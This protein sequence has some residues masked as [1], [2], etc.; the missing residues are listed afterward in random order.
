MMRLGRYAVL[1]G[2]A[3]AYAGL[4][5]VAEAQFGST[6]PCSVLDNRPCTPSV[7]SP[8]DG[9]PCEP[10]YP[11]PLGETLQVTV[12]S[13]QK[14]QGQAVDHDHPVDTIRGLFT[15]LRACWRP[16]DADEAHP[17]MQMSVRFAFKR[18]GEIIGQPRMTYA[19]PGVDGETR[20]I[21]RRAIDQALG[22]CTPVPFSKG[23]GGAIAGRPIAIRFVDNR[24]QQGQERHP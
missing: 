12:N 21:Y 24:T 2:A 13:T 17:G 10:Q 20:K 15:A 9:E 8:L 19:T 22:R 18:N 14:T 7:C 16:P 6:V 23:M 11:F 3:C 4:I 5:A 1:G